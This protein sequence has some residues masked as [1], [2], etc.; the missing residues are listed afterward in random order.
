MK[1]IDL[2]NIEM[3]PMAGG[4]DKDLIARFSSPTTVDTAA[5]FFFFDQSGDLHMEARAGAT[6]EAQDFMRDVMFVLDSWMSEDQ[7]RND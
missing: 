1:K 3:K 4:P 7:K 2:S 5:V 6:K